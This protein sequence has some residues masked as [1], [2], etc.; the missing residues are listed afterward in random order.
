MLELHKVQGRNVLAWSWALAVCLAPA[1]A[2]AQRAGGG[3]Q[4]TASGGATP[5]QRAGAAR[6][7]RDAVGAAS[8]QAA[9]GAVAFAPQQNFTQRS[10]RASVRSADRGSSNHNINP[11]PQP[12]VE[13]RAVRDG[14]PNRESVPR[15]PTQQTYPSHIDGAEHPAPNWGGWGSSGSRW[16]YGPW[17]YAR[18]AHSYGPWGYGYGRPY[19]PWGW[20]YGRAYAPWVY[21]Y[22]YGRPY[23]PWGYGYGYPY[24]YRPGAYAPYPGYG[25]GYGGV[26][27]P[28]GA[29]IPPA[30][31]GWGYY[32]APTGG[33][34]PAY[35]GW[36]STSR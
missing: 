5:A 8:P 28:A 17:G 22:G 31:R 2:L 11:M 36:A 12:A 3:A 1:S 18:W 7:Q 21:G 15:T 34:A 13:R 25:W 16:G 4:Q 14:A 23:G 26:Y 29:I 19:G 24:P 9:G 32:P 35:R 33:A 30:Y 27:G 10:E 6:A 20:G